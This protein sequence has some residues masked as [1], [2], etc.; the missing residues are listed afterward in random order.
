MGDHAA[1]KLSKIRSAFIGVGS[2]GE[3]HLKFF[4]GLP[5][6]EVVAIS[7]LYEDKVKEKMGMVNQMAEASSHSNIATYWG[8]E[9]R[10]KTMLQEVKPD[11]VFIAT[12][13]NNHAPMAIES[14]KQGA[15][16][17]VEV[18][19]GGNPKRTVGDCRHLGANSE[20]L[21]DDGKRQLRQGRIDVSQH[22]PPRGNR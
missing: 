22:V 2:R 13:W 18:P 6:T 12:N 9:N 3:E 14:M 4:A 10:W 17:F 19:L 7:D 16:A 21:Y 1:P 11:V 15:H 8:D 20:T 5:G